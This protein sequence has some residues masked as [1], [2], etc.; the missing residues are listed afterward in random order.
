MEAR[1]L[2]GQAIRGQQEI[3]IST[4]QSEDRDRD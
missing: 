4:M 2:N 1:T 3:R